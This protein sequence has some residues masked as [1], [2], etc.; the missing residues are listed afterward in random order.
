MLQTL[1][2]LN[3]I[4]F[5]AR[6]RTLYLSMNGFLENTILLQINLSKIIFFLLHK[7]SPGRVSSSFQILFRT[8]LFPHSQRFHVLC[9]VTEQVTTVVRYSH[10]TGSRVIVT[11]MFRIPLQSLHTNDL[12]LFLDGDH[13]PPLHL[14]R[15]TVCQMS[16][17]VCTLL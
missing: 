8:G 7:I 14:F 3:S 4:P 15:F 12:L 16:L 17:A 10:L 5:W 13:G 2:H 6:I 9:I 11:E 1:D